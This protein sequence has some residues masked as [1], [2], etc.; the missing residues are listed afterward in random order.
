V[1]AANKNPMRI[2]VKIHPKSSQS[3]ILKTAENE[4]EV[5]VTAPPI[6]GKANEMLQRLLADY[7]NV[8]KSCVNIIGGKTAKTKI[9]DI[10]Q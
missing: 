8:S 3:K 6:Q 1:S 10:T 7:F 2:Y 4:Y 9:I 5:W